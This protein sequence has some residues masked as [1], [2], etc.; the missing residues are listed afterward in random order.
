MSAGA[1]RDAN[2]ASIAKYRR[3]AAAYDGS[4]RFTQSIRLRAIERLGLRAGDRVLDVGSGTGLS[5]EAILSRIGPSGQLVGVEQSPDMMA[6]ARARVAR[7]G[8]ANVSLVESA[9]EDVAQGM[10]VDAVLF[11]YTHDILRTP[12]A[13]AV[14]AASAPGGRV[15]VAGVKYYP[16][17]AGPANAHVWVKNWLYNARPSGLARPWDILERHA[18]L[19]RETT[20]WGRGYL[21]WGRFKG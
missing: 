17:W 8:W 9:L 14:A 15:A 2:R 1:P 6:Q 11:F 4:T 7:H 21:A 19:E 18:A 3:R 5:F 12:E 16:W 13:V 20:L 10:R